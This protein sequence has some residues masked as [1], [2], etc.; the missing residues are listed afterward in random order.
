M[1]KETRYLA[2]GKQRPGRN[3]L[4]INDL[5]AS[6][7]LLNRREA[8]KLFSQYAS[9][10]CFYPNQTNCFS[11]SSLTCSPLSL[12]INSVPAFTVSASRRNAFFNGDK[13]PGK[14]SF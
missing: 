1:G 14:K 8:H 6:L 9:L 4:Y 13:D 7:L 5:T 3:P 10:P 2:R 12:I 11:V